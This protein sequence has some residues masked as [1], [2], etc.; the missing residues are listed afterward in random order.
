M[1][2]YSLHHVA[3]RPAKVGDKLVST[4]FA[5]SS[6]R[7]F[8]S[9]SEPD[10]AVCLLPGTELAFEKEVEYEPTFGFLFKRST[11]QR[12]ARFR[13]INEDR[14][15]SHHDALEFPDA[16][17]LL[18]TRLSEGQHATVLQLPASRPSNGAE[19]PTSAPVAYELPQSAWSVR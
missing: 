19:K 1:C 11:G 10:V 6:T 4:R 16:D 18:V 5:N 15:S 8:A 12:V 3:S 14:P 9:V 7:G 2:D 13:H 17:T